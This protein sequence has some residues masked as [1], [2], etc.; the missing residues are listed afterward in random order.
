MKAEEGTHQEEGHEDREEG[1]E[2]E[3]LGGRR[4]S[5]ITNS[6]RKWRGGG[7][8]GARTGSG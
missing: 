6:V 4:R 1:S 8:G 7:Q 3:L 2:A 5:T